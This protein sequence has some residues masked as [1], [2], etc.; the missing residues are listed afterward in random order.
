MDV[1][2]KWLGQVVSVCV[3]VCVCVCMCVCVC[4]CVCVC[5]SVIISLYGWDYL[6]VRWYGIWVNGYFFFFFLTA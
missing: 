6:C 5:L 4:V 3:H 1:V 2:A